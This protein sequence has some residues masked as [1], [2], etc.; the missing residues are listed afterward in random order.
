MCLE[1]RCVTLMKIPSSGHEV[2]D[3]DDDPKSGP[4]TSTNTRQKVQVVLGSATLNIFF[5]D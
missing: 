4:T 5:K 1:Q 2:I 3:T